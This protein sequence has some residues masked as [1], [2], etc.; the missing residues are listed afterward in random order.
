M[1]RSEAPRLSE[2]DPAPGL[3]PPTRFESLLLLTPALHCLCPQA[4]HPPL[5]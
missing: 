2:V 5:D 1:H 3:I 4:M